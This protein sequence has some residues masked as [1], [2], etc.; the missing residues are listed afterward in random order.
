[1][2]CDRETGRHELKPLAY[3]TTTPFPLTSVLDE[4]CSI[5]IKVCS[6]GTKVVLYIN[7]EHIIKLKFVPLAYLTNII[8]L[9]QE[10]VREENIYMYM[11]NHAKSWNRFFFESKEELY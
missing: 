8:Q 11:Y 6:G 4:N 3:L 10:F 5:P 9:E 2:E 1:L 7:M